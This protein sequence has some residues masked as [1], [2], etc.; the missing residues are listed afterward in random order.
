MFAAVT[1]PVEAP[2]KLRTDIEK[3]IDGRAVKEVK[4]RLRPRYSRIA[5]AA[6]VLVLAIAASVHFLDSKPAQPEMTPEEA[7]EHTLMA[8]TLLTKTVRKG[9]SA[10]DAGAQTASEAIT[11]AENSLNKL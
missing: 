6:A 9:Y 2:E 7:R 1:G 11:T 8:L 3:A 4:R 10:M 5:A